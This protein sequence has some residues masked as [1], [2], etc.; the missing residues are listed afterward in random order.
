MHGG[1]SMPT[2]KFTTHLQRFFPDLQQNMPVEGETVAAVVANLDRRF[3]G[4][5]AYIVD[6]HGK[7]RKHVNIFIEDE[8]IQDRQRL[9]D[10]VKDH[11]RVFIFQALSGG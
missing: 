2:L 8:L 9:S 6:E 4:L 5:A 11:N 1:F 7:L 3:P 10:V